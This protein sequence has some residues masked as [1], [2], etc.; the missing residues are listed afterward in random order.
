MKK[1]LLIAI[2]S[3]LTTFVYGQKKSDRNTEPDS[4]RVIVSFISEIDGTITNIKFKKI[5]CKNCSKKFK[6]SIK[7]SAIKIIQS[8]PK[9]NEH[10]QRIRYIQPIKFKFED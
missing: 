7:E 1:S 6:K 3:L 10:K 9:I 2:L 8:L 5:E 4:V